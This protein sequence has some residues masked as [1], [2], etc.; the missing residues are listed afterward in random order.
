M[1]TTHSLGQA[2]RQILTQND[3][4]S[5]T[6]PTKGLYPYQWNWD[7]AIAA[8]GFAEFDINRAWVELETLFSGQWAD[9]MVPHI[10][11]H[12]PDSGYFPGPDVWGCG[13]P[14]PSS[15]IIQPPIAAS[16]ARRIWEKDTVAGASRMVV[17]YPKMLA[18]HRWIMQWRLDR[19]AVCTTHPWETGRDNAP[20]WDNTMARMN[21]SDVGEYTR[22]D[23]AHVNS[24]DRPTKFDYDRYIKLVQLGRKLNWDQ[25]ALREQSPFRVADPTM[26]FTTLGAARDLLAMGTELGFD[27][28]GLAE[29]IQTLEAGAATLWNTDLGAFDSRDVLS[30][31]WAE[32]LSNASYL[33]WLGGIESDQMMDRL[34]NTLETVPYP[35]PSNDPDSDTFDAR[36]YWRGPTWAV[37][38]MLIGLGLEQQGHHAEAAELARKTGALI[39]EHGFAEY[40]DP[41]SGS[42]AGGKSFTWTAA[43]WLAWVGGE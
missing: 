22:R 35:V 2:A 24:D 17:L 13:G 5:Y 40:F 33:C 30:G 25:A 34:R 37:V 19:G 10:L 32:C 14:I 31:E 9:G 1:T 27:T 20:D 7:S 23:T 6:I 36:R 16:M 38:N 3:K 12:Q 26:T 11:F 39:S 15:G 28:I 18:W 42:P 4:G 21:A 41:L 8:L 29:D 43:V